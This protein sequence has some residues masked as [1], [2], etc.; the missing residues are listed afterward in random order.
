M[1]DQTPSDNVYVT[2]LPPDVDDA[3]VRGLF[4]L[5]A[6]VANCKAMAGKYPGQTGAALVRFLSVEEAT[7]IVDS[8][9]NKT[10]EGLASPIRVRFAARKQPTEAPSQNGREPDGG[11]YNKSVPAPRNGQNGPYAPGAHGG[12]GKKTV[13]TT[14]ISTLVNGLMRSHNL[15]PG[16]GRKPEENSLYITGLPYNTT[17]LDLYKIFAPF[18]A[19]PATGVKAA[20][21]PDGTCSGVGFVDF[22]DPACA[23]LAMETLNGTG[24]PDGV[25]LTITNKSSKKRPQPKCASRQILGET[26]DESEGAP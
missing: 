2:D 14:E 23:Q 25:F 20:L 3:M 1:G 15:L 7:W 10:L 6:P 24:L 16:S 21:G 11:T 5:Y 4:E 22:N 9:N 12:H 18:G 13:S 17:N 26:H 19:I 8:L